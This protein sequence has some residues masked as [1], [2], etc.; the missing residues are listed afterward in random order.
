MNIGISIDRSACIMCGCCVRVC[1]SR[2]FSISGENGGSI[3]VDI[4][5]GCIG[6]GHCVDVCDNR[7]VRHSLF[8]RD[9]I[10][11]IDREAIPAPE[12]LLEL[13][14]SRRSNRVFSKEPL[15]KELLDRIIE[16]AYLAPTASNG[17]ELEFVAVTDPKQLK[18]IS[19][20]VVDSFSKT[21]R[22]MKLPIVRTI[23]KTAA[24]GLWRYVPML[25]QLQREYEAGKDPILRGATAVIFICA[26]KKSLFGCHNANLAYQNGSLMA[27]SL[28]VKFL[29]T[30]RFRYQLGR[31]LAR[32]CT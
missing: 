18:M 14:R 1:P 26:P 28:G 20:Y 11:R 21:L 12:A 8:S 5:R 2:I 23:I 22:Q 13:I 6:C 30:R 3:D 7:A 17:Q 29:H 4:S 31:E 25:E 24:P 15:S 10:H 19:R 9:K 32:S 27:E 16:A